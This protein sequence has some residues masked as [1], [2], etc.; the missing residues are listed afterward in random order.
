M[1]LWDR[2]CVGFRPGLTSSTSTAAGVVPLGKT[3]NMGQLT[4]MHMISSETW[5]A[6]PE[7]GISGTSLWCLTMGVVV[8]LARQTHW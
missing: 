1:D 8:E 7:D 5:Q 2:C 4:E 3:S 6:V